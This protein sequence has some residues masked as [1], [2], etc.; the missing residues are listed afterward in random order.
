M[1]MEGK[2]KEVSMES[3][4][5]AVILRFDRSIQRITPGFPDQVGE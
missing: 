5:N 3:F 1:K 4:S 2:A